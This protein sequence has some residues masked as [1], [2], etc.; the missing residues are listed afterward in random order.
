MKNSINEVLDN[1]KKAFETWSEM[2]GKMMKNITGNETPVFVNHN[3]DLVKS[4]YNKQNEL[5]Q[6]T[7]KK[8]ADPI[9]AAKTAPDTFKKMI[10]SQLEFFES[11]KNNMASDW[12]KSTKTAADWNNITTTYNDMFT[13]WSNWTKESNKWMEDAYLKAIPA[14]MKPAYDSYTSSFSSMMKIWE[15]VTKMIENGVF[16]PEMINKFIPTGA[17]KN[18]VDQMT[19]FKFT[20]DLNSTIKS[21]NEFFDNWFKAIQGM[22]PS[23][24]NVWNWMEQADKAYD[25]KKFHPSF[26]FMTDGLGQFKSA[27]EPMFHIME[28]N[29]TTEI[30]KMIKDVQ[31]QYAGLAIKSTELQTLVYNGT[32]NVL[33]EVIEFF[34]K[35]YDKTK[36]MV[37]PMDFFKKLT[38]IMESNMVKVF[39][40]KEY[41]TLQSEVS[42]LNVQV[43]SNFNVIIE[44]SMSDLPILTKTIGDELAKEISDLKRK[45]RQLENEIKTAA[46][47]AKTKT[48]SAKTASPVVKANTPVAKTSTPAVKVIPTVAPDV[49]NAAVETNKNKASKN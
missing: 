28:Q 33:A 15:P 36:L 37:Q 43:K 24:N 31:F 7:M 25:F 10:D 2:T 21:G 29:K 19:N 8:V 17:F 12:E 11:W 30:A 6:D 48:A 49:K 4:W 47:A 34:K 5:V 20:G 18:I 39:E 22:N 40:S 9:E 46:P 38:D 13:Q 16:Q 14:N 27:L 23:Q 26:A 45:V 44:K 35:D 1:Q 32:N 42:K 3:S 41:S